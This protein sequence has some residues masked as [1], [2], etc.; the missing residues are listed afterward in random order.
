MTIDIAV[1]K[2]IL[3]QILKDIYSDTS[4]GPS[5]GF[6]GGT[7]A[8]LFYGLERFSVDIDFDLLDNAK[9][10]YVYDKLT[11]ITERY[12]K[13]KESYKKQNTIFFMISYEEKTQNIKVEVNLRSF[14]SKYE[15]KSYLGISMKVMVREDMAAHKLV[16]MMER[17]GKTNRDIYDVWFFLKNH[18]PINKAI[19]EGRTKMPFNAF[20][21][22]CIEVLEKM[23]NRHILSGMGE[24]LDNKQK[25]WVKTHLQK[26]TIFLLRLN[27]ETPGKK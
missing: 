8:F 6:K 5:M 11:K 22:R 20:L 3:L 23:D 9:T 25:V 21:G 13:I 14:G 24:L 17:L 19:V 2:N 27:M 15:V 1:H 7:A 16:A 18:W 10:D 12:G 4:L 26:D